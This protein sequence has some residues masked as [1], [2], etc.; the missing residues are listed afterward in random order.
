MPLKEYKIINDADGNDFFVVKGQNECDAALE[1]L[2][3]L[4][5]WVSPKKEQGS[6]DSDQFEF[7]FSKLLTR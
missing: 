4:G 1:A 5:W 3:Q 6:Y 7:S 2:E